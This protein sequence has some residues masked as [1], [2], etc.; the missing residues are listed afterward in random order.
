MNYFDEYSDYY[1]NREY[2]Q[3][4]PK[5]TSKRRWR[6]IEKVKETSRLSLELVNDDLVYFDMLDKPS[7]SH[8]HSHY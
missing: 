7:N 8:S 1:D 2:N 4:A 3:Q 6:D 5:R